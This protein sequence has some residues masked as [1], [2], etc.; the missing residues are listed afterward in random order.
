MD[1]LEIKKYVKFIEL[2]G[3]KTS[4]DY[5]QKSL[6]AKNDKSNLKSCVYLPQTSHQQTPGIMYL[7]L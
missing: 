7:I 3:D 4:G 2:V 1:R 6:S 5:N